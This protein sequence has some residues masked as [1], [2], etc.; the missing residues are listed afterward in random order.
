MDNVPSPPALILGGVT[1]EWI[2]DLN[3]VAVWQIGSVH[4]RPVAVCWS[5]G[6]APTG[7]QQVPALPGHVCFRPKL[8]S[9][10]GQAWQKRLDATTLNPAELVAVVAGREP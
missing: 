2:R 10:Q 6:A 5:D 4:A 7:W 1:P 8:S 3:G 9:P